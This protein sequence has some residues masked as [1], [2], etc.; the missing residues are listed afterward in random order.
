[1]KRPIKFIIIVFSITL[2][3]LIAFYSYWLMAPPDKTCTSCHEIQTA[4]DI[5][6]QSP[7]RDIPCADC[8]GTATSSGLHGVKEKTRM[9]LVHFGGKPINDIRLNEFQLIETMVYCRNCHA[10]EY[11]NWLSSGHSATYAAIFL[12]EKHNKQEQISA[13]CLRCHGMFYTGTISQLV[14]PLDLTGPW[15]LRNPDISATPTIPCMACHHIH[16]QGEPAVRPDYANPATIAAKRT[17]RLAKVGFYDR[18]EKIHFDAEE[19]PQLQLTDKQGPIWVAAD[20]RQRVCCQCHAPNAFHQAGSSDDRTPRG[21]HEGLSCGACHATHSNDARNSCTNC[22]PQLSNCGLDVEKMNTTF[23]D[24]GSPNN[25]HF[26]ACSDCHQ[27]SFLSK[28]AG[29]KAKNS[30][31]NIMKTE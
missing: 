7:H 11:A 13:S 31:N 10:R 26:V 8:H 17:P 16:V 21:V 30:A 27:Q 1:M 24:T 12:D 19:L 5:W 25:I 2:L 4:H 29:R 18:Y 6:A 23:Y 3:V 15:V 14:M 20:A 28:L 9:I 22:H